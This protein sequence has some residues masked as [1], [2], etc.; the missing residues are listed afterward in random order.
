MTGSNLT[1]ACKLVFKVAR[2]ETNDMLFVDSDV[3]ELLIDGLG[4]ASPL[5]D[6]EACIYGYGAVRFLANA[7]I[8]TPKDTATTTTTTTT[9]SA[10]PAPAIGSAHNRIRQKTIAYRLARHGAVQL[11]VLHLQM[12]NESGANAKLAGPP[13]HAMFQLAGALRVLAKTPSLCRPH[14][15]AEHAA[16][17]VRHNRPPC[18][19]SS[20]TTIQPTASGKSSLSSLASSSSLSSTSAPQILELYEDHGDDI[21]LHL[22]CGH[23]VRAGEVCIG[24]DEVQ[25]NVVR[26]LSVLSELPSCATAL[27]DYAPRLGV[28]LGP[29]DGAP[30]H[31]APRQWSHGALVLPVRLGYALGNVMAAEDRARLLFFNNDVAMEYLV[32]ALDWYAQQNIVKVASASA[33]SV[34]VQ[35]SKSKAD[36]SAGAGDTV[37]DVLVKLVRVVANMSVNSEVGYGLG[38]RPG[39]GSILLRLLQIVNGVKAQL[40]RLLRYIFLIRF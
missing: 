22:A 10:P 25:T 31:R 27:A 32:Q 36:A 6:P 9:T 8:A 11:M 5:D 30:T 40:V 17:N 29:C 4:R 18:L 28:L 20:G 34:T 12:L 19:F 7:S 23:L 21:Q 2:S 15:L 37:L 3:P 16:A 33:T 38:V 13:L 39:L 14:A 35:T 26:T 1:G 24:A